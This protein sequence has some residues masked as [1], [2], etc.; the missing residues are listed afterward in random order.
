MIPSTHNPIPFPLRGIVPPMV[1][2]LSDR[3]RLDLPGLERLIEHLI[4]GGVHG[5]FI[6]GTTGEATSLSDAVRREL[7]QRSCRV[8]AGRIPVLVGV[9]DTRVAESIS[10][11]QYSAEAGASGVVVSAPYYLPLEQEELIAYVKAVVVEQPLPLFL[12][13]I[14]S[15]TK[16][17]YAIETVLRLADIPQIVGMKD[18]SG[19]LSYLH[20]LQERVRRPDWSFFVGTEAILAKAVLTGSHGCVCGG[21]N[22]APALFVSLYEAAV[23]RDL[24]HISLLQKKVAVLDQIYHVAPGI[25]SIFRGIKC[26]LACRGICGDR[27]SVPLRSCTEAE[28]ESIRHVLAELALLPT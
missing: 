26:A 12:Y 18:S 13:N 3:D 28:R 15:L 17:A 5:L 7:I 10:L 9:T 20:D 27:M 25:A 22:V 4:A 2:P 11:A 21:A 19:Q 1:T 14:P 8:I 24:D 16:T 23:R 6:L